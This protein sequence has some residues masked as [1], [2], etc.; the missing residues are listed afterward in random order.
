MMDPELGEE[1][2]FMAAPA[3]HPSEVCGHKHA[4]HAAARE[5]ARR[6]KPSVVVRLQVVTRLHR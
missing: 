1:V 5:C 4:T 3:L 2:G 6:M